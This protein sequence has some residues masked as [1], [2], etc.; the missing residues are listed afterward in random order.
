MVPT[1]LEVKL[2]SN[3]LEL[4]IV[5]KYSSFSNLGDLVVS[6]LNCVIINGCDGKDALK[7]DDVGFLEIS[8]MK[9]L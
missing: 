8:L 9:E 6:H 1:E 2:G 5:S 7:L 3:L 4:D